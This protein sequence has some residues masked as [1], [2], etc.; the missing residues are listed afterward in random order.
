MSAF[1]VT[2]FGTSRLI[3]SSLCAVLL[4]AT[5]LPAFAQQAQI[6]TLASR[7]A[8]RIAR[9]DKRKVFVARFVFEKQGSFALGGSLSEE[10]A[11]ELV[12]KGKNLEFVDRAHL[13]SFL[14]QQ[15]L[16][17]IDVE[18]PEIVALL[19]RSAGVDAL[20]MGNIKERRYD[21][22]LAVK[23]VD[24]SSGKSIGAAKTRIPLTQTMKEL[25]DAP[26]RDAESGVY[27][28]GVGGVSTPKCRR[29]PEPGFS[30]EARSKSVREAKVVVRV[31]VTA[32]G[33]LSD[34]RV[35]QRAGYGLDENSVHAA[36]RWEF[37]PARLPDGTA[38]PVRATV[39]FTFRL[40]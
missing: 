14:K 17:A 9:S 26:V 5:T 12:K 28:A 3:R 24:G 34:I 33:R 21:L 4:A 19:A 13:V 30:D 40:R 38:V 36:Q 16:Q 20:V 32:E 11:A 15:N 39:E 35:L 31:T 10:F 8:E 27:L 18:S 37:T 2:Q 23:I 7:L 22:E 25:R 29:C 1:D 6:E